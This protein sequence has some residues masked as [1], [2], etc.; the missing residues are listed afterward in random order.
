MSGVVL[1]SSALIAVLREEPGSDLV[2]PHLDGSTIGTIN[3]CEVLTKLIEEGA[4]EAVAWEAVADLG[5]LTV[6]FD[7]A[8]A[9]IA[10][11]LRPATRELGLSLG[12]RA[13]LALAKRQALPVVTA[14]RIWSRLDQGV[15]IRV[16]RS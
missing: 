10:A 1:D 11:D 16:V 7:V 15:E 4:P 3:L 14:D 5:L 13:C 2:E 6:D 12:D 9:R 8:L